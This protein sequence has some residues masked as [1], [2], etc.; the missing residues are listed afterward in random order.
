MNDY[1]NRQKSRTLTIINIS[2]FLLLIIISFTNPTVTGTIQYLVLMCMGILV[3]S[4]ILIHIKYLNTAS[5]IT[6]VT[7]FIT[8]WSIMYAGVIIKEPII[9]ILDTFNYMYPSIIFSALLTEKKQSLFYAAGNF[10]I[11]IL[12]MYF[13]YIS[14]MLDINLC[15]EFFVDAGSNLIFISICGY[16]I[17]KQSEENISTIQNQLA[18]LQDFNLNLE[19]KV[20]QRTEELKSA[21]DELSIMNDQLIETKNELWG[22][23]ELAKKIQTV[24]LPKNPYI[25]GYEIAAYMK[26]AS[27]VGGDYYDVINA[28]GNDWIVIG[29]VSGHGVPA[30][31]I[32]M[33][34][35]TAIHVTIEQ[36]P[37][38]KPSELLSIINS[39]IHANIKNLQDDKYMTINVFMHHSGNFIH[40]GLHQDILLYRK[41]LNIVDVLETDGM[42]IGIVENIEKMLNNDIFYMEI[43]DILLLYTDG[44]TE[45]TKNND[46]YGNERLKD[47]LEISGN[48]PV[49]VIK[50]NILNSLQEYTVRDDLTFIII[51]RCA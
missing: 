45:A 23:M 17:I 5:H 33:M 28:G 2:V 37:K 48:I 51:K 12:F 41:N 29:D 43:G 26:P 6:V 1:K 46:L 11:L 30:G 25:K 34:V 21:N 16:S 24:L 9:T 7:C 13:I 27:D 19:K 31:L 44:I 20:E 22:E 3:I 38:L 14:N 39:T 4:T 35:Q 42:W 36:N 50:G 15:V 47:I 8:I 10:L 49:D 18:L 32:M 40:A